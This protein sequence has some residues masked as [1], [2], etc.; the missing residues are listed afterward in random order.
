MTEANLPLFYQ[1]LVALDR[2]AHTRLKVRPP[3]N[4]QFTADATLI[5]LVTG[6]FAPAAREF[7]IAFLREPASGEFVPVALTGLPQSKNLFVTADGQWDARYMPTYIRR[8]PFVFAETSADNF[9]VCFDPSSRFLDENEGAPLFDADGEPSNVLKDTIKG[10]Q[11]YQQ[12]VRGTKTFMKK[13]TEA[14]ILMEANAKADLPDGRSFAWRG[15]WIVDEKLF[16]ELPEATV[17]EWF[18]TG[19]LGL[20]YAHLVS[21]G[22]LSELLRRHAGA[23][24]LA[25]AAARPS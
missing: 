6:E 23:A 4:F 9:A 13:I 1:S 10:L 8:Y 3:D 18:A 14:N 11:D 19:D 24:P 12:L 2:R 15:F 20:V 25:S 5:P 17:K 21:I 16:R 22:N 7:P